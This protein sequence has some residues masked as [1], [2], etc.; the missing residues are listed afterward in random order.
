MQANPQLVPSQL[1]A[2]LAAGAGHGVHRVPQVA[3]EFFSTHRPE[4][5]W[6]VESHVDAWHCCALTPP[7]V[8]L[9]AG[10]GQSAHTPP[11]SRSPVAQVA[12]QLVP[13]QV[14]VP[15]ATVGHGLHELPQVASAEFDTHAPEQT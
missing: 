1:A 13:L 7:Q 10:V 8:V 12:L 15:F 5:T 9:A 4:Q 2:P 11:H 3:T 14:A 6:R